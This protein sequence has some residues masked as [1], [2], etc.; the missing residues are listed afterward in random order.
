METPTCNVVPIVPDL[1][2]LAPETTDQ[3]ILSD[4]GVATILALSPDRVQR[5]L[6]EEVL[7]LR[8]ALWCVTNKESQPCC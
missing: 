7:N 6:A 4:Q 3:A 5:L 8:Q 1:P 2:Y